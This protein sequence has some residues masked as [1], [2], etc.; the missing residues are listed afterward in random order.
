MVSGLPQAFKKKKKTLQMGKAIKVNFQPTEMR[1]FNSIK[2][3][4][5]L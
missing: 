2:N 5:I 4:Y 1:A 3:V